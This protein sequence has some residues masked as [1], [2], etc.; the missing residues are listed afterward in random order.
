MARGTTLGRLVTMLR[1]ECRHATSA[2]LGLNNEPHLK[3]IL[4]RVQ[5][6][7]W[8]DYVWPHLF[9]RRDKDLMAGQRYYSFPSDLSFERIEVMKVDVKYAGQWQGVRYGIGDAEYN[10]RDSDN[11]E[12]DSPV[13]AWSHYEDNQFEVWP[14]PAADDEQTLRFQGVKKLAPLIA[15]ENRAD[16]D[17]NLIVLF[18]AAEILAAQKAEDSQAKLTAAQNLYRRLKQQQSKSTMIVMGGGRDPN[19]TP[20]VAPGPLYGKKV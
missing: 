18:A 12:R 1:E 5:E 8:T 7:L 4:A 13:R 6:T 16:L 3:R 10:S 20:R 9:V 19:M 11:D 15:N 2:A 14:I 17:D